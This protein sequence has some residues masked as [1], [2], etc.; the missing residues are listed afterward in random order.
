MNIHSLV[1]AFK[2]PKKFRKPK[3]GREKSIVNSIVSKHLRGRNFSTRSDIDARIESLL[4]HDFLD[5]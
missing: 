2:Y 1:A 3:E 5:G 4:E